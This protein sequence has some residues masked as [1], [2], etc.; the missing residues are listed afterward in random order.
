MDLGLVKKQVGRRVI[1]GR[2]R[3]MSWSVPSSFSY[4]GA[5]E[6]HDVPGLID[7]MGGNVSFVEF[8]DRHF[9]GGHN[10][11]TNEPSHHIVSPFYPLR[12]P[13][14]IAD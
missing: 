10:L 7:T 13:S 4:L 8:M 1:I 6:Q 9:E 12:N 11:H 5:H 14:M 2:T 3:L